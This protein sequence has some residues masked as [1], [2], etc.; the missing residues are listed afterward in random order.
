[1]VVKINNIFL[2]QKEKKNY[3]YKKITLIPYYSIRNREG[4]NC[5]FSIWE[6]WKMGFFLLNGGGKIRWSRSKSWRNLGL[7]FARTLSFPRIISVINLIGSCKSQF[8]FYPSLDRDHRH[9]FT[10]CSENP[11]YKKYRKM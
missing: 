6:M 10:I 1:M 5:R 8:L 11:Y 4:K 2:P 7:C 3:S 9:L